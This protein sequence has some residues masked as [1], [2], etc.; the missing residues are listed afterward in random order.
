MTICAVLRSSAADASRY[1]ARSARRRLQDFRNVGKNYAFLPMCILAVVQNYSRVFRGEVD[2]S[3]S[4]AAMLFVECKWRDA[5]VDRG[6]KY[7]KAKFADCP[8]MASLRSRHEGL[9]DTRR[10]SGRAGARVPAV[11]GVNPRI[12][13]GT[14]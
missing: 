12:T 3:S 1:L 9:R 13:A 5:E 11:T 2:F 7:L 10:Y 4:R 14:A 6:L 8:R